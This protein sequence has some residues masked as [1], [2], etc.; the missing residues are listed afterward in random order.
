MSM[1]RKRMVNRRIVIT[2]L[3]SLMILGGCASTPKANLTQFNQGTG[4][5]YPPISIIM[6]SKYVQDPIYPNTLINALRE[7]HVF[8]S[9]DINNPYSAFTMQ[10]ELK[11]VNPILNNT[12]ESI[13]EGVIIGG[14]LGLVPVRVTFISTGTITLRFK[15]VIFDRFTFRSEYHGNVSI[16]NS[17]SK[18][19]GIFGCYR[20]DAE[21]ILKY[22]QERKSFNKIQY[23]GITNPPSAVA[24]FLQ[25]F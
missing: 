24:G 4:P 3:F 17:S 12:T 16:F 6:T 22:L 21:I 5:L 7:A 18:D 15:G 8:Q 1:G 2:A 9:I 11:V 23:K 13:A 20:K 19:A 10:I 14:T 25:V